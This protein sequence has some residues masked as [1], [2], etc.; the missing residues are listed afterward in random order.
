ML[1]FEDSTHTYRWHGQRIPSVTQA[2]YTLFDFSAVPPD[3]L[4]RKR[5]IGVAVHKAIHEE[6]LG[7]LDLASIDAASLPYF[8]AWRR[9]RDECNFD[10]VLIEYRVT[11]A[12]LGEQF[13]YAGTLDEWGMLQSYH[14]LIDWKT[15]L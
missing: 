2:L 6:M 11:S 14:A 9:F 1:T 5:K 12:E 4:E 13:R 3:V 10:P 15:C 8:D 7:R